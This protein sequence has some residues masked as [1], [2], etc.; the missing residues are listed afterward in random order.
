MKK[1]R[2]TQNDIEKLKSK[3]LVIASSIGKEIAIPKSE[4]KAIQH[5]KQVLQ[6]MGLQY[7]LEHRFH[8]ARKYRFD[9]AL[10]HERIAI[11]YEGLMSAKSGHT[12]FVGYTK[13]CRKY[14]L[15][16]INNWKILR[17]TAK[18]YT[19]VRNDI[20]EILKREL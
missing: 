17:Y 9:L 3:G 2:W 19:D 5:I 7:E 16:T 18:N 11:E 6:D 10:I 14:N 8:P 15:A 20:I 12:T 4:P 13:D 1:N